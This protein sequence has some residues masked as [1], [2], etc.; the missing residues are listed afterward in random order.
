MSTLI[1]GHT[2]LRRSSPTMAAYWAI[3][4]FVYAVIVASVSTQ[5]DA[6]V[7]IWA[8]SGG[9]APKYFLLALGIML[10]VQLPIFVGNGVTRRDFAAGASMYV[11]VIALGYGALMA[12]GFAVEHA[13]YSANDLLTV[14][15]DPYPVQSVADGLGM[16]V[17]ETIVGMVY[18]CVGWLIGT[19]FYRLGVWWGIGLIPLEAVPVA[20]A[21]MGFNSLWMGYGLN[22]GLGIE[23]PPLLVG[24]LI[25]LAAL[26]IL[27]A[28][29]F[30]LLRD[31]PIKKVS[32]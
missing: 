12:A 4:L 13:I 7:S 6:D 5:A 26:A 24:V 22:R 32:G 27:W 21:E 28:A 10:S 31:I 1:V 18:L 30:V 23:A 25:G 15:K 8:T 11:A 2:M 19:S 3:M 14:Q 17:G 16:F 20:V 9:S 29:N